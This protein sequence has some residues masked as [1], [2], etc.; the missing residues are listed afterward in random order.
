M[1]GLKK[2]S[3]SGN[4]DE[5]NMVIFGSITQQYF[6]KCKL[7]W[8]L[9]LF[10]FSRKDYKMVKKPGYFFRQKKRKI[11]ISGNPVAQITSTMQKEMKYLG[12]NTWV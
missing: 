4:P 3:I 1:S 11:A 2:C 7:A 5:K 6:Q 12:K 8:V 9:K 10:F